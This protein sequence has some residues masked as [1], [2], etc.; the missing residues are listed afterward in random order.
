MNARTF[1]MNVAFVITAYIL[2][3]SVLATLFFLGHRAYGPFKDAVPLIIAIPAAWL[4]FCLQR[5]QAYLK[6]VRELWTK[7][8]VSVQDAIQYTHL[9]NP[10]Q[11][12]YA[13]V[14]RSLSTAI[15]ELRSVFSNVGEAQG[16]VGLYPFECIKTIHMVVSRLGFG[17]EMTGESAKAARALIVADW[18]KL[19]YYYLGE[20]ER[21]IPANPDS[22]YFK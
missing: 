22:P 9:S 2:A 20:L 18:K 1:R 11:S 6:E 12:E 7:L 14:L 4:G 15:E 17:E 3:L 10:L 19:R 16:K 5:R 13:K 8:V 21:G